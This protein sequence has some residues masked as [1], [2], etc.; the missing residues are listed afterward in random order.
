M[1]V[2]PLAIVPFGSALKEQ[3]PWSKFTPNPTVRRPL[4]IQGAGAGPELSLLSGVF[5]DI[6]LRIAERNLKHMKKITYSEQ[7]WNPETQAIR[8]S[9]PIE[10]TSFSGTFQCPPLSSL[11]VLFLRM[12]KI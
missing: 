5:G 10:R 8:S 11:P 12:R 9:E 4:V 3:I 6:L 2:R 1:Q 7:D